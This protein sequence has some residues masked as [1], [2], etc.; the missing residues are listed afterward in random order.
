MPRAVRTQE[1]TMTST[2][3][4]YCSSLSHDTVTPQEEWKLETGCCLHQKKHNAHF[5]HVGKV[6]W[7]NLDKTQTIELFFRSNNSSKLA[8]FPSGLIR[9]SAC[10]MV[11]AR[12]MVHQNILKERKGKKTAWLLKYTESNREES[13]MMSAV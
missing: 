10:A 6:P 5:F 12:D 2:T 11:K 13:V 8:K 4:C 3:M 7:V 9:S 1:K